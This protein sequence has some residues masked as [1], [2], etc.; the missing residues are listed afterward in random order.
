MIGNFE[1][2]L[3]QPDVNF[4]AVFYFQPGVEPLARKK[5]LIDLKVVDNELGDR[6][7]KITVALRIFTPNAD[8]SYFL[9][10]G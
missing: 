8:Y 1:H 5:Q 10:T 9:T 2:L 4:I 3:L 7:V 6:T